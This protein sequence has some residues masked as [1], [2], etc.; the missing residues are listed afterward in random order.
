MCYLLYLCLFLHI[1][2]EKLQLFSPSYSD[3]SYVCY[4]GGAW[5]KSADSR[6]GLKFHIGKNRRVVEKGGDFENNPIS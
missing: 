6:K 1:R 4:I 2:N 5:S 3:L